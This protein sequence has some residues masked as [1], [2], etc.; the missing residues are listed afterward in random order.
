[1]EQLVTSRTWRELV[2]TNTLVNSG[3]SAPAIVPQEIII[4]SFH[5]IVPSSPTLP[6]MSL[7]MT[8]V[9]IIEMMLV[10]KTRLVSGAS[11]FIFVALT[12][13]GLASTNSLMRY[14]NPLVSTMIRRMTKIQTRS[15][16]WC[17]SGHAL[18]MKTI[19]ATPVTP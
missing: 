14:E 18:R 11:K 8:N 5:Q 2:L 12:Y 4:D 15:C 19:S 6:S 16:A 3:I 7:V 9:E 13:R 10:M 1:M 17:S